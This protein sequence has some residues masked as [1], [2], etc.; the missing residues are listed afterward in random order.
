MTRYEARSYFFEP[1]RIR[2]T[3]DGEREG[4]RRPEPDPASRSPLVLER[5]RL[6]CDD[7][8]AELISSLQN[9]DDRPVN[10]SLGS[11]ATGQAHCLTFYRHVDQGYAMRRDALSLRARVG[12]VYLYAHAMLAQ[13][14]SC[15]PCLFI[16]RHL[17]DA[18]GVFLGGEK[19]S[20]P[21]C[22]L[23]CLPASALGGRR[24][25][26]LS[27]RR[28]PLAW[29]AF[30]GRLDFYDQDFNGIF[31]SIF[32]AATPGENSIIKNGR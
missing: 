18:F 9:I 25:P 3:T 32:I 23:A 10:W 1:D 14:P 6:T 31:A 20:Y 22:L 30:L 27:D 24:L 19:R 5:A 28:P 11:K 16:S 15:G 17:F 29:A 13:P 7:L 12:A 21:V 26:I 4:G 2:R 8:A